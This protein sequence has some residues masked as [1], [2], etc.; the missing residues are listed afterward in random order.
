LASSV[1]IRMISRLLPDSRCCRAQLVWTILPSDFKPPQVPL[2]DVLPISASSINPPAHYVSAF[3]KYYLL[4]T[5]RTYDPNFGINLHPRQSS[6]GCLTCSAAVVVLV[7]PARHS[8]LATVC[9]RPI[10]AVTVRSGSNLYTCEEAAGYQPCFELRCLA[11][12]SPQLAPY[13]HPAVSRLCSIIAL[14]ACHV[15]LCQGNTV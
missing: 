3:L 14:D 15:V 7:T 13:A 11:V 12:D 9:R 2:G 1:I 4:R 5:Y 10:E 6:A 8:R